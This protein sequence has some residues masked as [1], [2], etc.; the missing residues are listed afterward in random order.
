MRYRT[1]Y[2]YT[3]RE[4][5]FRYV[6]Q[7]Y[8]PLLRGRIL[9][10]GADECHLR[11]YLH[12]DSEY[13]GIGHGG[14]PDQQVDLEKEGLP[15]PN[16]SYDCVLC[17]DVLEHVENIH[18]IFDECCRVT[19]RSVIV[20]LPNPYAQFFRF[21][22]RGD[23]QP[24][25]PLKYYGLPVER[26]DDRHKWFFSTAE[27]EQFIRVRAARSGMRVVQLDVEASV[28]EGHGWRG[29]LRSFAR[30]VLVSRTVSRRDLYAGTLWAV[31]ESPKN[32]G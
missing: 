11:H 7:K 15:F 14:S 3:D 28:S 13:W 31:L 25:L 20:S 30:E 21:L 4:T 23:Y 22:R 32:G 12:E 8:R 29:W 19:R 24:G 10:V 6:W 5:K 26:P 18:E 17:L 9:D 16:A 27:A 1:D 2:R